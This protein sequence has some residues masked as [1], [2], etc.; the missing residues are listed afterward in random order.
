M[1]TRALLPY[2]QGSSRVQPQPR[3]ETER[4]RTYRETMQD[5]A[6][7]LNVIGGA[8]N[9]GRAV[10]PWVAGIGYGG[11]PTTAID[12]EASRINA[13]LA[14]AYPQTTPTQPGAQQVP[15]AAPER[16][17]AAGMEGAERRGAE[18]APSD[19]M[20]PSMMNRE[21]RRSAITGL[22]QA[23]PQAT[24]TGVRFNR[25][26][27]ERQERALEA[28][29]VWSPGSSH[30]MFRQGNDVVTPPAPSQEVNAT[31]LPQ[32]T[33]YAGQKPSLAGFEERLAATSFPTEQQ[34]V[35]EA[36]AERQRIM[37]EDAK[38]EE[39]QAERDAIAAGMDTEIAKLDKEQ[40]M[41]DAL[42]AAVPPPPPEDPVQRQAELQTI[43]SE[44]LAPA[45]Q[46]AL[47]IDKFAA[48]PTF[49][50]YAEAVSAM[51]QAVM[52]GDIA[53]AQEIMQGAARSPLV[54]LRPTTFADRLS[55]AHVHRA[56]TQLGNMASGMN[57]AAMRAAQAQQ[58]AGL[59][60]RRLMMQER[61]TES[62]IQNRLKQQE[63][64][65]MKLAQAEQK[66][67]QQW[68]GLKSQ[69]KSRELRDILLKDFQPAK[70]AATRAAANMRN[71]FATQARRL[72]P[73]REVRGAVQAFDDYAGM[74]R[75]WEIAKAEGRAVGSE[76]PRVEQGR[77]VYESKEVPTPGAAKTELQV[78]AAAKKDQQ[79][80]SQ[81]TEQRATEELLGLGTKRGRGG[82]GTPQVPPEVK[83]QLQVF[84]EELR[85]V[86][87]AKEFGQS[88]TQRFRKALPRLKKMVEQM[89]PEFRTANEQALRA[90]AEGFGIPYDPPAKT[91][92]KKGA[93]RK[94]AGG[95]F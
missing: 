60:E 30:A 8:V 12:A 47:E 2:I 61:N 18:P 44:S 46:A 38:W 11:A 86:S 51:R 34:M 3:K 16:R 77:V 53:K 14:A 62:M 21:D 87:T 76:P 13:N 17:P 81:Q 64:A 75:D 70:I 35:Q 79:R 6:A 1:A 59:A 24:A 39:Q 29:P 10:E 54:D 33:A 92:T 93:K 74:V 83:N 42:S 7:T 56:M 55:G 94:P 69:I 63:V 57:A 22:G 58:R 23:G 50:T 65:Q 37:A 45:A 4:E 15:Q 5:I 28:N 90:E 36:E 27:G 40:A 67:N 32:Q 48:V 78:Q 95:G 82:S 84:S 20:P 72:L 25:I 26:G 80:R 91:G 73:A 43:A 19:R 49:Q 31:G 41:F 68:E 52:S 89:P 66:M 88:D 9:I 71:A 85:R